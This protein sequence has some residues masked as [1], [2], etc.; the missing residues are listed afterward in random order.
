MRPKRPGTHALV[1][2]PM[3]DLKSP[4][5]RAVTLIELLVVVAILA[6]LIGLL[7]GAVQY[8]RLSAA[9][10]EATNDARQIL[11]AAHNFAATN[12]DRLPNV[13]GAEPQLPGRSVIQALCPYLE[14]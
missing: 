3:A 9:R 10:A 13:D 8:A 1:G 2:T 11:L 14:A 4:R 5:R 6:L 12:Q 7:L